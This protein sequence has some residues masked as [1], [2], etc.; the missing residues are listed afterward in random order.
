MI[1]E[2]PGVDNSEMCYCVLGIGVSL[3]V[4]DEVLGLARYSGMQVLLR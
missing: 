4:G 1:N 3:Q 2:K